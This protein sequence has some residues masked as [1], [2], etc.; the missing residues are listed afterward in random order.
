VVCATPAWS[1]TKKSYYGINSSEFRA[2]GEAALLRGGY[3]IVNW[4]RL[5]LRGLFGHLE[6]SYL[7]GWQVRKLKPKH[8]MALLP[9]SFN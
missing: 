3:H 4:R 7:K 2:H 9:I 6:E 5:S 1:R 8:A